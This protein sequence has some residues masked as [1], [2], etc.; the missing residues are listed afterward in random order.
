[1]CV[2][3]DGKSNN[4]RQTC[5]EAK[6]CTRQDIE[7]Y[8]VAIGSFCDETTLLAIATDEDHY[9]VADAFKDLKA[10]SE[11]LKSELRTRIPAIETWT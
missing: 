4:A 9:K 5:R 11:V 3:T 6:L 8:A 10:V 1:M 2:L 7:M